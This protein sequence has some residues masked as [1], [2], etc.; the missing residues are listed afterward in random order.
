MDDKVEQKAIELYTAAVAVPQWDKEQEHLRQFYRALAE[1][2]LAVD[3]MMVAAKAIQA[4]ADKQ[5]D[6]SYEEL[7]KEREAELER[8]RSA[9][10]RQEIEKMRPVAQ[11]LRGKPKPAEEE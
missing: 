7:V 3:D 1:Q 9:A 11:R 8:Q 6:E 10:L 5:G 2:R 4:E